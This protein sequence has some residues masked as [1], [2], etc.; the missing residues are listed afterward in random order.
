MPAPVDPRMA[1]PG[2][3][4]FAPPS[5]DAVYRAHARMVGRWAARLGGKGVDVED[6]IQDVFVTVA[7]RL[8]DFRGDAPLEAWLYRI[9]RKTVA[10]L[11]RRA[12][13][14]RWLPW[15]P[16]DDAR[17]A[18][19][20][21]GPGDAL[22]RRQAEARFQRLLDTLPARYREVLVLFELEEIATADIAD[23]LQVKTATVRVWLHRGRAA[24]LTAEARL[25]RAEGAR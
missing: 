14:R 10:N 2:P 8:P 7:R 12:R 1:V 16:D 17:V 5:F 11:R 3:G 23:L 18:S 24:F 25:A 20:A 4:R 21:P 19:P 15:G 6:A 13:L 22:E 9:T